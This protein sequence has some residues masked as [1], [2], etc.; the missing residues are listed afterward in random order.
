VLGDLLPSTDDRVL[1]DYRTADDAGVYRWPQGPALVQTVD[2][3]APVVDDPYDYG[4]IAAANALSDVYA[5]GG[6]PR[7]ALAIA[8]WPKNGPDRSVI[9]DI[10]RG[11]LDKLNEAGAVLL[12][13]HTVSDDEIKFGYAVTGAVDPEAMWTNAGAR[14]GDLLILTKPLGTGII[15]T[16]IKFA[17]ASDEHARAATASMRR[18]NAGAAAAARRLRTGRVSA[19]TDVTGFGLAGHAVEM[20]SA[21][22]VSIEIETSALPVLPGATELAAANQPGGAKSNRDHFGRDV[23]APAH[24]PASIFALVFDPQTS[25]G[26][27]IAAPAAAVDELRRELDR[28]GA[29]SAVIGRVTCPR[30]QGQSAVVFK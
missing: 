7:T 20:A 18:L 16:A 30:R 1:V 8:A 19:C 24:L 5:M 4:Q 23:A 6:E 9:R 17:R 3:F 11:G 15:A 27:L 12:G 14:E 29:L 21:S 22:G 10:F 28:E 26:L 25:G 2:F 13:G